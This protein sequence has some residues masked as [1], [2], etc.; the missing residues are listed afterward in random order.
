MS[1]PR[2]RPRHVDPETE[3]KVCGLNACLA[4]FAQRRDDIIRVHVARNRMPAVGELLSWCAENHRAYHV[5]TDE[6]LE[7]LTQS[8]HHEG[9]LLLVR[10]AEMPKFGFFVG[11]ERVATDPRCLVLLENVVNPHNLGAIIR[12]AAHFGAHGILLAGDAPNLSAAV[13]RTAEGGVEYVPVIRIGDPVAA[14]ALFREAG[15]ASVATSS[16]TGEDLGQAPLPPKTLFLLGSE[17]EGLS[18]R[19]LAAASQ[20]VR[21]PGTGAVESLNVATATAVLLADFRRAHPCP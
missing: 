21:I 17:N 8:H 5:V 13:Y 18:P 11:R 15:F 12:V 9:I 14:V 3:V 10:H 20:C 19:L 2:T 16:H 4:I 6:D 1:V 7:K